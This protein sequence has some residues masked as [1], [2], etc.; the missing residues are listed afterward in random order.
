MLFPDLVL[1]PSHCKL[2]SKKEKKMVIHSIS[3]SELKDIQSIGLHSH[4]QVHT[5]LHG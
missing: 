5:D 4:T 2:H 3:G 1:I